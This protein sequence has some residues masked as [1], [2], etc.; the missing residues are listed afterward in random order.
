ME[1]RIQVRILVKFICTGQNNNIFVQ[2]VDGSSFPV[3]TKLVTFIRTH[4]NL[5][6][7]KFMCLEGG[8][9]ACLVSVKSKDPVTNLI[10]IEAVNSV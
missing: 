10:R 1:Y 7:T 6:G 4:A 9:G 5:Q 3:E 8:C 2:L